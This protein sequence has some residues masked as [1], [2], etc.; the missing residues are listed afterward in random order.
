MKASVTGTLQLVAPSDP[1][2][3]PL[4]IHLSPIAA[5]PALGV[6]PSWESNPQPSQCEATVAVLR[7]C[8]S[9]C[10]GAIF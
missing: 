1:L 10:Q 9:C 6:T 4:A 3:Q 7:I 8:C 5:S 2:L